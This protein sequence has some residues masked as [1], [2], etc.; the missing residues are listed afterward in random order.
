M[1]KNRPHPFLSHCHTTRI[2][3][4]TDKSSSESMG[5]SGYSERSGAG[6]DKEIIGVAEVV[7]QLLMVASGCCQSW[8]DISLVTI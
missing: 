2:G 6:I 3:I 1:V 7:D 4:R 5:N 8:S